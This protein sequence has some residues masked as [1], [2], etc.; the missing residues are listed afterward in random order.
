MHNCKLTHAQQHLLKAP[1]LA[2]QSLD[3]FKLQ[4]FSKLD[5]TLAKSYPLHSPTWRR[6][7]AKTLQTLSLPRPF[8]P[9]DSSKTLQALALQPPSLFSSCKFSWK[10]MCKLD[11]FK[12]NAHWKQNLKRQTLKAALPAMWCANVLICLLN[13]QANQL[14]ETSN[15]LR[16]LKPQTFWSTMIIANML[17]QRDS[18][19]RPWSLALQTAQEA[20]PAR[21]QPE[22]LMPWSQSKRANS[23]QL[24]KVC[25]CPWMLLE[26]PTTNK[27][28][29]NQ[30]CKRKPLN[31]WNLQSFLALQSAKEASPARS[32]PW[33]DCCPLQPITHLQTSPKYQTCLDEIPSNEYI[34]FGLHSLMWGLPCKDS[35]FPCLLK[36]FAQ[37][38]ISNNPVPTPTPCFQGLQSQHSSIDTTATWGVL[39]NLDRMTLLKKTIGTLITV[40][41]WL[42]PW[43]T[44]GRFS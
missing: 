8:K 35:K 19:K 24:Y 40:F 2:L 20:T 3:D 43:T 23:K 44:L 31:T 12:D 25:W 36:S 11:G 30:H 28:T 18:F 9:C 17:L 39:D 1:S 22:R 41:I 21:S 13:S 42:S 4:R 16:T 29:E 6:L 32:Q 14:K 5:C 7:Q 33:T 15:P 38:G 37:S 10:C 27:W 26:E 34:Q